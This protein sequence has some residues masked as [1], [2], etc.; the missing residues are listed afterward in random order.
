LHQ[1]EH[2]LRTRL[3]RR[4]NHSREEYGN[5]KPRNKSS[6]ERLHISTAPIRF[7]RVRYRYSLGPQQGEGYDVLRHPSQAFRAVSEHADMRRARS[8]SDENTAK[9][10]GLRKIF[11]SGIFSDRDYFAARDGA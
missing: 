9:S 8:K 10:K 4:R 5:N 7:P 11:R 6:P 3:A 2:F 1:R